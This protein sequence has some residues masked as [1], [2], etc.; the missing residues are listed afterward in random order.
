MARC[1]LLSEYVAATLGDCYRTVRKGA[2]KAGV[3]KENTDS[4]DGTDL[5]SGKVC[6][7]QSVIPAHAGIQGLEL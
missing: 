7:N 1:S 5:H 2:V 4:A 3:G 6:T